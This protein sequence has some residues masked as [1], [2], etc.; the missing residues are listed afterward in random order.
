[1]VMVHDVQCGTAGAGPLLSPAKDRVHTESG[2]ALATESLDEIHG[3]AKRIG[4]GPKPI[5]QPHQAP[6]CRRHLR[7]RLVVRHT[8]LAIAD[9]RDEDPALSIGGIAHVSQGVGR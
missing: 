5:E 3:R 4:V 8:D 9:A 1:M 2:G 7:D 6:V